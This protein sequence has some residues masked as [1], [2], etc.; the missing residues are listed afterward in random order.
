MDNVKAKLDNVHKLLKMQVSSAEDVEAVDDDNGIDEEEDVNFVSGKAFRIRGL[1]IRVDTK[2]R[3]A[4]DIRVD[5]TR[6]HSTRNPS[7]AT[8]TTAT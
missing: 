4:M 6:V 7:A 3:M 1:E 8:T 5:T 2:T